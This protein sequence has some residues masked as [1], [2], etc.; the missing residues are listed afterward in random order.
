MTKEEFELGREKVLKNFEVLESL[1]DENEDQVT[2]LFAEIVEDKNSCTLLSLMIISMI[3]GARDFFD[4]V[5]AD[6]E[7]EEV[8]EVLEECQ[9]VAE[10]FQN[11]DKIDMLKQMMS[12]Y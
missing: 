10:V 11:N 5:E 6:F 3:G 12:D 9:R 4:K 8:Q 7:N 2:N 1:T